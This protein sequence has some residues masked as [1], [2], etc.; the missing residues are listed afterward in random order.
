MKVVVYLPALNEAATIGA[1][2]DGIPSRL[3]GIDFIRTIVVDDGST[4]GTSQ[5]AQR[6]GAAVVRH[7][8]NLG[9][10]R[11]FVSGVSA[12]LRA[13]ADIIV[14]MDAD[15]QFRGEDIV[16]LIAPIREGRADIALC[17]R[18]ADG[19]LVGD[20]SWP[21]KAGNQLLTG[22]V[23]WIAGKRFTDVSC[24]FRAM[25][26]EAALRVDIHSDYE[27]IHESLLNWSRVGLTIEEVALPVLAERPV[28]E[29]RMMRSVL[30]YGMRS[31]PVLIR[32]ARDYSPMKFFGMLSLAA[33]VPAV[34]AGLFV[35][36]HWLRTGETFPYTSLIT[37]SVGGVLLGLLLGVVALLA[38]LI[39]RL[40][41][42]LEEMLY[43]SRR[44]RL[45][46]PTIRR[47]G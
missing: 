12:A 40:R 1:V 24:G 46:T 4:D 35:T 2:L 19:N 30:R 31:G 33:L 20:M 36:M 6:H 45:D 22:A 5:I 43:E 16:R 27:Y 11:T 10:G 25:S 44:S 21:K 47:V 37:I 9:T 18:F 8:R 23:S 14:S 42:Q 39:A 3:P 26:R 41:F 15:G 32:A 28:G 7:S 13:G 29:S 34:L 17:S 38:D